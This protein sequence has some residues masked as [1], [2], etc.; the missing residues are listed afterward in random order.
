MKVMI[1]GGGKVGTYLATYLLK[2][3]HEVKVI[4]LRSEEEPRM[5]LDLPKASIVIGNGTDPDMLESS[6]IRRMDVV[7]AVTGVDEI[8]LTALSLAR[9]EF[10]VPRTIARINHPKNAWMF[11]DYMGV[12]VAH[13]QADLI[14]HLIAEEMSLGDM[15]TLQMLRRGNYS[16]VEEKICPTARANGK[17]IKDLKLPDQC[18]IAAVL[19]DG[20]LIIPHEDLVFQ[21]A[22]EV[23]AIVHQSQKKELARFFDR[24]A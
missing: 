15:M 10:L 23:L 8:N 12:D 20:K 22:D 9:F 1:I 19:R 7:A 17:A 11:S 6:G 16:V 21:P 24:V 18:N 14:A 13:N 3:K 2:E 5:L 4:E